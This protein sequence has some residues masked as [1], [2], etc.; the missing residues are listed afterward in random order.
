MSHFYDK[1]LCFSCTQCSHCCRHE[2]GYVYLSNTDLTNMCNWFKL[3][4]NDF[5]KKYCRKVSYYDGSTV[6]CLQEKN[7]YDCIFWQK[8]GCTAYK[9]RPLQC[10]T[11]PFWSWILKNS[12]TWENESK[13]CPGINNGRLWTKEEI[14]KQKSLYDSILPV[15]I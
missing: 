14:I 5:I 10:S 4:S 7:N 6:L 1:G 15:R 11:Y 3:S 13:D 8:G 12:T 9:C 2:P